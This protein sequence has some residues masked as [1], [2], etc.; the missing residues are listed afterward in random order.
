MALSWS[1]TAIS[2]GIGYRVMQPNDKLVVHGECTLVT[3]ASEVLV[4]ILSLEADQIVLGCD[5]DIDMV[6]ASPTLV[7]YSLVPV[8]EAAYRPAELGGRRL[9]LH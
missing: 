8:R 1:G 4:T 9:V 2:D 6:Q 5:R 3:G 7:I